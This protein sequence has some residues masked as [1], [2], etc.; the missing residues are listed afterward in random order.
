MQPYISSF[1]FLIAGF[2]TVLTLI[3][4]GLAVYL[5]YRRGWLE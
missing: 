5:A 2:M 1:D 4:A 3:L